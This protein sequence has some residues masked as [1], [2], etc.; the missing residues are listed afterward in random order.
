MLDN[1]LYNLTLQLVEENK[2]IKRIRDHY[3]AD[4][5]ESGAERAFWE[6]L[7]AAKEANVREL[8]ALIKARI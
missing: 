7:A 1:A 6:A 5:G 4:A 2:A 3:L 8:T